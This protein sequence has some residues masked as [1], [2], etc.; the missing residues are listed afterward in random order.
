MVIDDDAMDNEDVEEIDHLLH[1]ATN[2][3]FGDRVF[4]IVEAAATKIIQR[5]KFV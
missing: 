4:N 2:E 5:V 1:H 3:E